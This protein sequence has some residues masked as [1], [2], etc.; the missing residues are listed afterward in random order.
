MKPKSIFEVMKFFEEN[1]LRVK[2]ISLAKGKK[3]MAVWFEVYYNPMPYE[4]LLI[5]R[6]LEIKEKI[7]RF[8]NLDEDP[9]INYSEGY[10]EFTFCI[11][12]ARP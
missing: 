3:E 12:E 7:K 4:K 5:E 9:T 1:R 10:F 2:E 8:F 6:I 11:K